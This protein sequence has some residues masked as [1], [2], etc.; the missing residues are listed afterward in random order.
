MQHITIGNLSNHDERDDDDL[1]YARRDW[2]EDVVFVGK[3]KLKQRGCSRTT[4]LRFAPYLAWTSLIH[5]SHGQS[6]IGDEELVILVT[7]E[8]K[9]KSRLFVS[10]RS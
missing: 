1:K 7:L 4:M 10:L 5:L 2:D 9:T 6:F 3:I 8:P